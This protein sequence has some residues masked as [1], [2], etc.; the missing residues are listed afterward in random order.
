[1]EKLL[2]L[3][4]ILFPFILLNATN[5]KAQKDSIQNILASY[6][7]NDTPGGILTI[8][9]TKEDPARFWSQGIADMEKNTSIHK[10]TNFRM[11]SVSKQFTAFAIIQLVEEGKL[12]LEQELS[13]F[14]PDISKAQQSITVQQLL[15]H[16]SGIWDFEDLI[17]D[18]QTD[19]LSDHG[20]YHLVKDQNKTYFT[21]GSTFRY[22]NTGY[23]LLALIVEKCSQKP[24]S[25]YMDHRVFKTHHL[26]NTAI[27]QKNDPPS[28]RAYGYHPQGDSVKFADQ[29]LTSA[30]KG[31]GGVYISAGQFA[32]WAQVIAEKLKSDS[33]YSHIFEESKTQIRDNL[34]YSLGWFL[35]ED[36]SGNR[37]IFH[38]GE[39]TGFHNIVLINL[40]SGEYLSLFTNRDDQKI[41]PLFDDLMEVMTIKLNVLKG[42][43]LF[44]F[45]ADIYE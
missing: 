13:E 30:T 23:I 18:D 45:L 9:K 19:Q 34:Y 42:Q 21:P 1:M 11:A 27:Y 28:N 5:Q 38:S 39:T 44:T 22:S 35:T 24:Y 10:T 40:D 6:Y 41:A 2:A 8:K 14:F 33:N 29:N 32:H 12:E 17:P 37:Y 16:T 3:Y 25:Q 7:Q 15:N 36:N 26:K 31:D 43:P 20:V 4:F